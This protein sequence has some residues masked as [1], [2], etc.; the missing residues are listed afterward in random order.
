MNTSPT[1]LELDDFDELDILLDERR[2]LD[3]E[4]PQWEFCEGF[5]A[6]LMCSP[7]A[8]APEQ[9]LP[10]LL[11]PSP[12]AETAPGQPW[13]HTQLGFAQPEQA[14]AF[15]A[16]WGRRWQEVVNQLDT[17]IEDLEDDAAY[18]PEVMD[19]RAAVAALEPQERDDIDEDDLPSFAQ[20]WALGF[21]YA[22]ESW[23]EL[24]QAPQDPEAA[25]LFEQ[26]LQHIVAMTE[27]DTEAPEISPFNEDGPPTLSMA[28]LNA[29]GEAIWA[30][31]DLRQLR[32]APRI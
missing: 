31:Y 5:M 24:W 27:D 10:V 2:L 20:V 19:V 11:G 1:P 13:D 17:E 8:L 4:T 18:Q 23:P 3:D 16:F 25:E 7:Q 15:L 6:A 28:R 26:A 12:E 30:V 29:F 9:F 32:A 21:M 14:Q 22:V